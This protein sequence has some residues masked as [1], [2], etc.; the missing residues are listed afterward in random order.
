M[1]LE[2]DLE[3]TGSGMPIELRAGL[4]TIIVGANG[5]GK[6]KLAV[7]CE[8]QLGDKAHRISAQR[9]LALDPAIEKISEKAAR[10]QLRY[11][12]AKPED[13]GGFQQAR[14]MNRWGQ[15][16]P[17]FI[18]NDAGALLQVRMRPGI[19]SC[20]TKPVATYAAA[21]PQSHSPAASAGA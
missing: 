12:Y 8:R 10:G 3:I 11:G 18:L 5:S 6:T 7:K 15:D 21:A 17:R 4:S 13:Y 19:P 16:Q 2:I 20:V 14:N 9:M 1:T